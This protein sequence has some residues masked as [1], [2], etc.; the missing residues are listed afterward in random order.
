M[1]L[2]LSGLLY[3]SLLGPLFFNAWVYVAGGNANFFYAITLVWGVSQIMLVVDLVFAHLKREW[4]KTK[5]GWRR[6]RV[7][8]LYQYNE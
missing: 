8:L 5:P 7:E 3:C 1:Y 2:A 6:M 4:E